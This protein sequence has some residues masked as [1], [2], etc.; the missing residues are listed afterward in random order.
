MTDRALFFLGVGFLLGPLLL[1]AGNV[2]LE[3]LERWMAERTVRL[4]EET[5][6]WFPSRKEV[7]EARAKSLGTT[8]VKT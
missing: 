6:V 2:F 8:K 3:E 4:H 1:W 7:K 5:G